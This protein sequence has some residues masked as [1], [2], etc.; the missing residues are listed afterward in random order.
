M[1]DAQAKTQSGASARKV[2]MR[3]CL[4]C[5]QHKPK[6]ELLRVVRSP[7]GD[8]SLDFVGKKSGR[9]AYICHDIKCLRRV[10]KSRRLENVLSVPISEEVYNQMETELLEE[11]EP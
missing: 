8:V 6:K 4:G 7:E 5:N 3:Q 1:A 11:A 10:R 2:P 9:G